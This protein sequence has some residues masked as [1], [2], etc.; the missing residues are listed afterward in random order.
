MRWLPH[1]RT[2]L[3]LQ[4]IVLRNIEIVALRTVALRE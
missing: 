1:A 4:C 3:S 2:V